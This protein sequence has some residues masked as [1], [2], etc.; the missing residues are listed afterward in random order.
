MDSRP[1]SAHISLLGKLGKKPFLEIVPPTARRIVIVYRRCWNAYCHLLECCHG[2]VWTSLCDGGVE[3]SGQSSTVV[4]CLFWEWGLGRSIFHV[5]FPPQQFVNFFSSQTWS[6]K[7]QRK[8]WL[9]SVRLDLRETKINTCMLFLIFV[10][11]WMC[12]QGLQ[13][14]TERDEMLH[15]WLGKAL[16]LPYSLSKHCGVASWL[17]MG[18]TRNC[19]SSSKKLKT[20]E[21]TLL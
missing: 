4:C 20:L 21:H 14:N 10:F 5:I 15:F 13:K 19:S 18:N 1:P 11:S 9:L 16:A 6:F 7:H 12:F 17:M 3:R 2:W 8:G